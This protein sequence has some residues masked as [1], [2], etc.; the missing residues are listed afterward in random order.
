M[1]ELENKWYKYVCSKYP[2]LTW[3][4]EHDEKSMDLTFECKNLN[5]RCGGFRFPI[6][7]RNG[8]EFKTYAHPK[9]CDDFVRQELTKYVKHIKEQ[10]KTDL[11]SKR[12][13]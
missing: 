5:L 12:V 11:K 4:V 1:T 13:V 10:C 3:R 9:V 2:F 6:M 8:A 7:Y